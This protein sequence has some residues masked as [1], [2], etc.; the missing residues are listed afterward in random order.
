M[1]ASPRTT[2]APPP[3]RAEVTNPARRRDSRSRPN[4][5]IPHPLLPRTTP[6]RHRSVDRHVT[7][8]DPRP[9]PPTVRSVIAP[10]LAPA[11]SASPPLHGREQERVAVDE[12]VA[13]VRTGAGAGAGAGSG[14]S[15]VLVGEAGIGKTRLLE[16]AAAAAADLQVARV[17]GVEPEHRLAYAG[18]HRLLRPFLGRMDRLPGPQRAALAGAFGLAAGSTVDFF[19]IGLATLALLADGLPLLCLVDD[20]QWLDRETLAVLAF[21]SRRLDADGVGLLIAALDEPDPAR[22]LDGLPTLAITGLPD[23]AARDLLAR[24]A[25][26]PVAPAVADR[27]VAGTGG[28]PLALIELTVRLSGDQLAG[29]APLP[30]PLPLHRRME[31]YLLRKVR[32]LPAATQSLLLVVAATGTRSP[33]AGVAAAQLPLGGVTAAR[34]PLGSAVAAQSPLGGAVAARSP[35]GGAVAARSPLGGAV[36]ARSPLGGAVAAQLPFGGAVAAQL[37]FGGVAAAQ[38]PLGGA[39]AD[40]SPIAGGAAVR[41]PFGGGAAASAPQDDVELWRAAA[42]LG[43]PPDAA[44]PAIADGILTTAHGIAFRHPLMRSAVHDAA[45]P[46]ERRRVH[47]ALAEATDRDTNPDRR[48]WHLAQATAGLDESVAGELGRAALQARVSGGHA[49]LARFLSRAA[50]LTPDPR[51]RARRLLAA[52]GAHLAADD[53]AAARRRLAQATPALHTPVLRATALR[54]RAA[55]DR[56]GGGVAN[57]TPAAML[58]VAEDTDLPDDLR[59]GAL[60]EALVAAI[61]AGRH[62]AGTTRTEVARAALRAAGRGDGPATTVRLLVEALATRLAVGYVPAVPRLRAAATAVHAER[63]LTP[64]GPFSLAGHHLIAEDLWDDAG[65]LAGLRHTEA[66]ARQRG[67]PQTVIAQLIGLATAATWSGDLE[68]AAAWHAE[69]AETGNL[70]GGPAGDTSCQVELLAWRGLEGPARTAADTAITVWE[71]QR[72]FGSLGDNARNSLAILELGLG[73]YADA[74]EH[75]RPAFRDDGIIHGNR[76]LP[77]L[78]EAAVRAGDPGTAQ[79]AL[80]RLSERATASGTPWALGVLARSRALLA[81]DTEAEALYHQAAGHLTG[82]TLATEL[83]RTHLLHGEWLR[84]RKRR[85]EARAALRTAHDAFVAMGAGAFADRARTELSATGQRA[86]A[87]TDAAARELTPQESQVAALAAQR[88]TNAEI[89]TRLFITT[90]TVEYHLNKIFR[91]LDVTSRRHLTQALDRT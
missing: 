30:D 82:T 75:L 29:G 5:V 31:V 66:L 14:A 57:M 11:G 78:I 13:A 46:A 16:H 84:R 72:G 35:L 33:L 37:P 61:V 49:S 1:P 85:T 26:G 88:A 86:R 80:A 54:L 39:V 4:S 77:N 69:A 21:V 28:N 38:P 58:A 40:R 23:A 73:R 50:D 48:A 32:R 20:A 74:L 9:R 6:H 36:A 17:A 52:A 10:S 2:S 68:R 45:P 51:P 90:S 63:D 81:A 55:L 60:Y 62:T 8:G 70:I 87:R 79:A 27:I 65:F 43:L 64:V 19:L 89:A 47:A 67:A 59:H 53:P 25:P 15:L 41:S 3:R 18:L 22:E 42:R 76:M 56:L 91:K 34:S 83:A 24:T 71:A 12:L 7:Y 44:D